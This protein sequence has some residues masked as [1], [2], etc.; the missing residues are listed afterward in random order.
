MKRK[1]VF[2]IEVAATEANDRD[3]DLWLAGQVDSMVHFDLSKGEIISA[4]RWREV[5]E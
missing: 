4:A 5:E 3:L 2:E 1:I